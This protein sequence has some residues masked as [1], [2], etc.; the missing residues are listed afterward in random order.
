MWT[1]FHFFDFSEFGAKNPIYFNVV[2]DP[3]ARFISYY[4]YARKGGIADFNS[5]KRNEPEVYKLISNYTLW[6]QLDF[7][8]CI[9]K[10]IYDCNFT[11]RTRR[12]LSIVC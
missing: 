11:E 10:E 7:N 8:E 3:V 5:K 6:L 4:Y 1:H 12:D 2:R 9:E